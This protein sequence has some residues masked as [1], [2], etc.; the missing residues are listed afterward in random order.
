MDNLLQ[1][2]LDWVSL[3]PH[4]AGL[5]IFVVALLES[6][7]I[8]GLIIPGALILFGVGAL[9]ATSAMPLIPTLA[10]ASA[11][12]LA[13]DTISF[14]IG[15]RYRQQ[16]RVMWPFCRYPRLIARG[17]DFF[18]RHGGKG[19]LMARFVGPVRP[20]LPA[21]AGM[22]QMNIG[23]F[24]VVD[25]IASLLWAP[26]YILP[27]MAFGASL[28]LAAEVAGR[29]VILLV[30]LVGGTWLF[31]WL[32]HQ[33]FRLV[34]PHATAITGRVLDWSRNHPVI[35]PM[36][37][38]LL[39]PEHPEA[40]GLAI[41]A[42]VLLTTTWF[43]LLIIQQVLQGAVLVN[44]D[45]YLFNIL[46]GL[47]TPGVDSLMVFI[48]RLGNNWLLAG[49]TLVACLWLIWKGY[50]K[51]A[52]HWLI[53]FSCT[54]LLTWTMKYFTR[55][56][57]PVDFHPGFS[58]PSAHSSMSL[59]CFGFLA[60]LI[61]HEMLPARR[62][63]AYASASLLAVLIAFSRLYLG[64]HWF[65]DVLA[66]LSMGLFWMALLG[67]AYSR[68]P[69]PRLPVRQLLAVFSV[70]LILAGG[71]QYQTHYRQDL[72]HYAVRYSVEEFSMSD[73]QEDIWRTFP[74]W[75]EDLEGDRRQPLNLQWAGSIDALREYLR[76]EDW[77]EPEPFGIRRAMAMFNPEP[78]PEDLPV[79][80]HIHGGRHQSLLLL[81]EDPDDGVLRAIRLWP[82]N[83]ILEE[84]GL[85]LW[86]GTL[87]HLKMYQG[88]YL[89]SMLRTVSDFSGPLHQLEDELAR[90]GLRWVV[91]NRRVS[92][93]DAM[94]HPDWDG[95]VLL[96]WQP[97]ATHDP[98]GATPA[99]GLEE[100]KQVT[101]SQGVMGYTR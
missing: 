64:V 3:H 4:W 100:Q 63:M 38:A 97:D 20:I 13:G 74:V 32:V 52:L 51:A 17:V 65:S 28:G 59:V 22:M 75:R 57:R 29:L 27:G 2:L 24:L 16:L 73:W 94:Q 30:V 91:R 39:D 92:K 14:W 12:A 96:V 81:H 31:L 95:E 43:F 23:K 79:L 77:Q 21:V 18:Y 99:T 66:G 19:I 85:P 61:A 68:H 71:W 45:E 11:G 87:T 89:I 48:T 55:V 72:D 88:L 50:W 34:Q 10:W 1:T 62:W 44:T 82:A 60:V 58:F 40:R 70:T 41:L 42:G 7:A 90:T 67:I 101:V 36:A 47:R 6:L 49:V 78:E 25:I 54:W 8:V 9:I 15:H 53:A 5:V 33:L 83:A 80:P 84:T 26:A 76:G 35:R 56:E 98:A 46:Q 69:N 37:G 93:S 86:V